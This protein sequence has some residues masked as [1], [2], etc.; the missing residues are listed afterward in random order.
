M[1]PARATL[2]FPALTAVLLL[3]GCQD[4]ILY[5]APAEAPERRSNVTP[6]S[7]PIDNPYGLNVG[8]WGTIPPEAPLDSAIGPVTAQYV[9]EAGIGW[10]RLDMRWN[11]IEE[12]QG[13][14][15][16]P[17]TDRLIQLANEKGLNVLVTLYGTPC[18]ARLVP[19]DC[20][21]TTL[22]PHNPRVPPNLN[23][24]ANFVS[25]V[26]NRYPSVKHWLVWNEPDAPAHFTGDTAQYIDLVNTAAPIIRAAGGKVVAPAT[27]SP[28]V[29]YISNVLTGAGHNIDIVAAHFY[30]VD[31]ENH[32]ESKSLGYKVVELTTDVDINVAWHWPIWITEAGVGD[33]SVDD[34]AQ[35]TE[36]QELMNAMMN[37]QTPFWEKTF[38]W[39]MIDE[40]DD[41]GTLY[42]DRGIIANYKEAMAASDPSLLSRR[43]AYWQYQQETSTRFAGHNVGYRAHNAYNGWQPEVWNG[44]IAGILKQTETVHLAIPEMQGIQIRLNNVPTGTGVTYRAY[45]RGN[46]W[47]TWVGDGALAGTAG[48]G[49][50]MDGLQIQ[51]TN[52][53]SN[54]QVCYRAYLTT[55]V[56]QAEVCDGQTA[57]APGGSTGIQAMRIRL[58]TVEEP[59]PPCVPEPGEFKC[60]EP[61]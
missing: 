57:G 41:E 45:V 26:V 35:A 40:Y 29:S 18:W 58:A 27:A 53:P 13:S 25:T 60:V 51:L 37:S 46:G 5:D 17:S 55:G 6:L 48:Q 24:W 47:Q 28:N 39:H 33:R 50:A 9:Q 14:W 38:Y 49:L 32:T 31:Y 30:G 34:G 36:L 2:I 21:D 3:G 10:V 52:G 54:L 4:D 11:G 8:Y 16:F 12:Y 23:H 59:P 43:T 19:I 61:S 1:R 20:G 42:A 22:D 44:R 56:W 7:G 15:D